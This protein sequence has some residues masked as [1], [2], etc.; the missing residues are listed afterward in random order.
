MKATSVKAFNV[1]EQNWF[2]HGSTMR[3]SV[4]PHLKSHQRTTETAFK[5]NLSLAT[6]FRSLNFHLN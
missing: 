6:R 1:M 3:A 5:E 2:S 4:L